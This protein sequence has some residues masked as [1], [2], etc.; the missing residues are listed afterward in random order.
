MASSSGRHSTP[1][2]ETGYQ[3]RF[4]ALPLVREAVLFL[5][6]HAGPAYVNQDRVWKG[7]FF[8]AD[9]GQAK[10]Y[11]DRKVHSSMPSSLQAKALEA[12]ITQVKAGSLALSG[13]EEDWLEYYQQKKERLCNEAY[14]GPFLQG[15]ENAFGLT[16]A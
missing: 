14:Y 11:F 7:D 15:L 5:E 9:R 10:R 12:V 2:R 16:G 3:E 1:Q 6:Q 13:P 4:R 8:Q